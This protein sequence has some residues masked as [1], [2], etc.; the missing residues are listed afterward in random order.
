MM[1]LITI[2][3]ELARA[4]YA[5]QKPSNRNGKVPAPICSNRIYHALRQ[6]EMSLILE[7][8]RHVSR[9]FLA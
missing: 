2:K 4:V 9:T 8:L 7:S 1:A 3:N 5:A 6:A